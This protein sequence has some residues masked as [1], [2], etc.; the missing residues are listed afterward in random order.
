MGKSTISMAIFNSFLYVYQRLFFT[1]VSREN[2]GE[3]IRKSMGNIRI[4]LGKL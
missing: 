1:M 4:F 2:D 3:H